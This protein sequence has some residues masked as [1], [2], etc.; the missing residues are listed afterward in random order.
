MRQ[1]EL[2]NRISEFGLGPGDSSGSRH[3]DGVGGGRFHLGI[4]AD[5]R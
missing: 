5:A 4:L 3:G 2:G 1:L